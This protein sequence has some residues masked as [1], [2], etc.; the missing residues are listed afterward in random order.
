METKISGV[1][2]TILPEQSGI[3]KNNNAWR[4]VDVILETEG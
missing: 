3:S 1:I 4:R 2:R